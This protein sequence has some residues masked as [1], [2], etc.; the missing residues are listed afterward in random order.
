VDGSVRYCPEQYN[1]IPAISSNRF[2]L[3]YTGV[4]YSDLF[5][6]VTFVNALA[7]LKDLD[8][9]VVLAGPMSARWYEAFRTAG[10]HQ[11]Q[12]LGPVPEVHA[13]GLQKGSSLLLLVGVNDPLRL[14]LKVFGYVGAKRPILCIRNSEHDLAANLTHSLR[15]GIVAANSADSIATAIRA[16]HSLWRCGNLDAQFEL[17][18]L[19]ELAWSETGAKMHRILT[20]L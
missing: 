2:R 19:H 6:P 4:F 1:R 16:A 14:P 10:D 15:R 3:V 13:I 7:Q 17:G 20:S 5:S 11:V 8:M 12:F 18:D 9:E